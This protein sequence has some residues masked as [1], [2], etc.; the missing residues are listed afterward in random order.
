MQLEVWVICARR[1]REEPDDGHESMRHSCCAVVVA[2]CSASG[3][4]RVENSLPI[5][6]LK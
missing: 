2:L 3:P 4:P 5:R 6:R 1:F